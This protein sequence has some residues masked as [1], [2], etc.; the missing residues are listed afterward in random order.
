MSLIDLL[1]LF[2]KPFSHSTHYH[3]DHYQ[4]TVLCEHL[5]SQPIIDERYTQLI[6]RNTHVQLKSY[7]FG[8]YF[9]EKMN[10][11]V[12]QTGHYLLLSKPRISSSKKTLCIWAIFLEWLTFATA[13]ILPLANKCIGGHLP[14]HLFYWADILPLTSF[15]IAD[16]IHRT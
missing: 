12:I 4:T 11:I 6:H 8:Q 2:T 16:I 13:D 15:D 3:R 9:T 10:F 14:P 5:F 7:I 1:E